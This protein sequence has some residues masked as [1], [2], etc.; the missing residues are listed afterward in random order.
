[1]FFLSS[2]LLPLCLWFSSERNLARAEDQLTV[3]KRFTE[4]LQD[5]HSALEDEANH[6][7]TSYADLKKSIQSFAADIASSKVDI[8]LALPIYA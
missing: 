6:L 7:R 8:S 2:L 5:Q 3:L 1:M 4:S